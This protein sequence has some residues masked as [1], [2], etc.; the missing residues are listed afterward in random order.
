MGSVAHWGSGLPPRE[1]LPAAPALSF[2]QP[3]VR[4][5]LQ[6]LVGAA[7]A[8][9]GTIPRAV[10]ALP[11]RDALRWLLLAESFEFYDVESTV[12]WSGVELPASRPARPME[13]G[14]RP[15]AV[16]GV[17]IAQDEGDRIAGAITSLLPCVEEVI[18]VDGGSK[19]DTVDIAASLGARVLRRAFDR[20]DHQRNAGLELVRTPWVISLD[21]DER[22]VQST[23]PLIRRATTSACEVVMLNRL[24]FVGA[25][26]TPTHWPT[27][28]PRLA[29][30]HVRFTGHV[31]EQV[32]LR[33]VLH[34]PLSL[35]PIFH[36]KPSAN[37]LRN[38]IRYM[39]MLEPNSR[40][41]PGLE[42]ELAAMPDDGDRNIPERFWRL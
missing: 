10:R 33:S 34:M 1:R 7:R 16:S 32:P 18:V 15:Q 9:G 36:W 11:L 37:S 28:A 12:S 6:H 17:I 19:D 4:P 20:F 30:R 25:D 23:L 2:S 13:A 29:R 39:K 5:A 21:C 40:E 42:A 26:P 35:N 31:H 27:S 38:H 3:E 14:A 22:L 8:N 41:L 24:N